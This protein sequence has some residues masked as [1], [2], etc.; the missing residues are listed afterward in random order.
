MMMYCKCGSMFS[1]DIHQLQRQK[2]CLFVL[3][4]IHL[5][6]NQALSAVITVRNPLENKQRTREC[7][8]TASTIF[9][10]MKLSPGG[11]RWKQHFSQNFY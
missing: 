5:T 10:F 9:I 11:L 8:S 7:V 1:L 3:P 2:S 6:S 4:V